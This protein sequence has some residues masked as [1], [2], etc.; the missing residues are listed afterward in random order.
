MEQVFPDREDEFNRVAFL[1]FFSFSSIVSTLRLDSFDETGFC[2]V[3]AADAVNVAYWFLYSLGEVCIWLTIRS[4]TLNAAFFDFLRQSAEII[5]PM[6]ATCSGVIVYIFAWYM[7]TIVDW[8]YQ[9]ECFHTTAEEAQL[10]DSAVAM[11]IF[12]AQANPQSIFLWLFFSCMS[13][14]W[15]SNISTWRG[16][17]RQSEA[18]DNRSPALKPPPPSNTR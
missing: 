8:A 11:S 3:Y 6:I 12:V 5:G 7:F 13:H 1:S 2:H 17:P 4:S 18:R 10:A 9:I 15:S 14:S 16:S